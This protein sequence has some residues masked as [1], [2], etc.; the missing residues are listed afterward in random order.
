MVFGLV[1]GSC[2]TS[3][4]IWAQRSSDRSSVPEGYFA[5]VALSAAITAL[6]GGLV[7]TA[8]DYGQSGRLTLTG[9]VFGTGWLLGGL[10][11]GWFLSGST[12][13]P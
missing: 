8:I 11:A 4:L 1:L 2:V 9:T 13:R 10:I 7:R 12:R 5:R 6:V 3:A